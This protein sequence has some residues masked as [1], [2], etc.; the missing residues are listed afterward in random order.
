MGI[1]AGPSFVD[2][3]VSTG[4]TLAAISIAVVALSHGTALFVGRRVFNMNEGVLFGTCFGAGTSAPA[5][6][7]VQEVAQSR[8]PTLGYGLGYAIG[9]VLLALWGAVLVMVLA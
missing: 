2:G 9:N 3:L 1:S 6:A 7:A 8:I 5:L 4:P